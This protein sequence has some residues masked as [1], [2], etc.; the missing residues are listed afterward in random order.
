MIISHTRVRLY[1]RGDTNLEVLVDKL[2]YSREFI[3][4]RARKFRVAFVDSGGGIIFIGLL[5]SI[6]FGCGY[7]RSGNVF[8]LDV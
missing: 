3:S 8:I 6:Q 4:I 2:C 1:T 7:V 5:G